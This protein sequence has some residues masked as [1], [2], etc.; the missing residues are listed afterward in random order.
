VAKRSRDEPPR[1]RL[2]RRHSDHALV[3]G[4]TVNAIVAE[5]RAFRAH[6]AIDA[7]AIEIGAA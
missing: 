1:Q 3:A 7:E 6:F 4:Q 5:T 2:F